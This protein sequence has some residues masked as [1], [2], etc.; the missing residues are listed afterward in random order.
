[1]EEQTIFN[2]V[3]KGFDPANKIKLIKLIKDL[4]GQGL[5]ESKVLVEQCE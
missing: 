3:L 1:M 5:K 4:T 2:L